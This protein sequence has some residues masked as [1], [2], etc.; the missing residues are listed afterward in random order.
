MTRQV[1]GDDAQLVH[2]GEHIGT[3]YVKV[4]HETVQQN[5]GLRVL[6]AFVAIMDGTAVDGEGT[7]LFH[8][9]KGLK[10]RCKNT[11]FF[12][13]GKHLSAKVMPN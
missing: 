1:D 2:V 8:V 12:L 5:K 6:A 10:I 3:P 11:I 7:V 4:L 9:G 13:H